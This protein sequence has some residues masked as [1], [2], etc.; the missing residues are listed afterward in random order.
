MAFYSAERFKG[1]EGG[2]RIF[3][4]FAIYRGSNAMDLPAIDAD[5]EGVMLSLVRGLHNTPEFDIPSEIDQSSD[6]DKLLEELHESENCEKSDFGFSQV[7]DGAD[8]NT[9]VAAE[10][11]GVALQGAFYDRALQDAMTSTR[12]IS[13]CFTQPWERGPMKFLFQGPPQLEVG[14]SMPSAFLEKVQESKSQDDVTESVKHVDKKMKLDNKLPSFAY[15]VKSKPDMTFLDKKAADMRLAIGKVVALVE[16]CPLSFQIGKVVL[17]E[18]E[19]P[20]EQD[21]AL[22]ETVEVILSMKSPNTVNKRAGALLLYVKWHSEIHR[23]DPFPIVEKDVAAYLFHL[24][25]SGSFISRGASFREAL[26]FAHYMLGLEGAIEACDSPRIK[27]ASDAMLCKG[28]PWS[29]A[30]PLLVSEVLLFHEILDS[31][32][33]PILDRIAAANVLTMVYGRCRASDLAFIKQAQLDYGPETGYLELSTQHHKTSRKASLKRKLLPIVIPVVGINSRNWVATMMNLR[34]AAGLST[35]NLSCE[36]W[37]P[38]PIEINGDAIK[39]SNRPVSSEEISDWIATVLK[40]ADT[41]RKLSSHSAKVTSLSWLSKAGVPREARDI[42][43]RHV[44]VL[45]GA[46]PLYARDL[47]SAP[48]RHL[49]DTIKKV[50]TRAFLPDENRSGM[51]TPVVNASAPQT[52]TV[53]VAHEL[54][55]KHAQVQAESRVDETKVELQTDVITIEDSD[56]E[57]PAA[58]ET[59]LSESDEESTFDSDVEDEQLKF[60]SPSEQSVKQIPLL[61]VRGKLFFMHKKSKICHLRDQ[62][63]TPGGNVNFFECGRKLS[64]N[65]EQIPSVNFRSFKC[66]LCFKNRH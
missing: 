51:F 34:E 16:L 36:P 52:P 57:K 29:P 4:D 30:D 37:W 41:T 24:R 12:S 23:G 63:L 45:H 50:A 44:T 46:G 11:P 53:Q 19:T 65:F 48:L 21:K 54:E 43:G 15:C 66:S 61:D 3:R 35:E 58:S 32:D 14:C 25:R 42:L 5:S 7:T 17:E 55:Q 38:A 13:S 33:K 39:W 56:E 10:S 47:I 64:E 59:S 49:E 22:L 9:S 31:C 28:S 40:S 6:R 2:I 18:N 27:G 8:E 20:D 60:L 1:G 26:R 62:P